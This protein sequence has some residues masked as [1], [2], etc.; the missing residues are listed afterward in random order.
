MMTIVEG[1]GWVLLHFVWQGA[2]IALALAIA[3]ALIGERQARLRYALSC[4]ALT[5]MLAATLSTAA[6]VWTSGGDGASGLLPARASGAVPAPAALTAARE[7]RTGVPASAQ[8]RAAS[9]LETTSLD[10]TPGRWQVVGAALPWLVAAWIGG[11]LLLSLRL[12]GGWWHTRALRAVDVAPVPDWCEARLAM[13]RDRLQIIRPVAIVSSIRVSVPVIVGHLK[14]VIV[15]PAAAL[16]G[17]SPAHL[18]AIIAHE[19]AHVR[20]HDYLVNLAQTVIETLLFY[21]PAVW[22][23]SRQVRVAREHCCDDLA[24]TVCSS[25]HEYVRALLDLE[26]L[27]DATPTLALGATD[28]SL[29]ARGRRLL[30]PQ[31]V[32]TSPPRLAASVIALVVVAAAVTGA[33]FNA[34]LDPAALVTWESPRGTPLIV[35]APSAIEASDLALQSAPVGNATPVTI[36][37][38]TAGPLANQW[39]WAIG[40]ARTA[41]HR[42]FWVGYSISPVKTLPAFVY[43][44]R[45]GRIVSGDMTFSGRI[46][47]SD[48]SGLRVPGRPLAL[49][50]ANRGVK[51]LFELDASRGEPTLASVHLSTLALPVDTKDLAV[52]WLGAADAAQS[53]DRIDQFYRAARDPEVRHDLV[54][55]AGAHDN[56]TA[57]VAWLERRIASQESD[58]LRGDAAESLAYH[59]IRASVTALDRTARQDRSTHVRQEAAE[60]L[61]DLPLP[62]ATPVLIDLARTLSDTDARREAVEALGARPEAAAAEAL[63]SI[64]RQDKDRDI[65]REAVETLGDFEDKRGTNALMELAQSHPDVEVRREAI[66]TLGDVLPTDTAVA[67]LKRFLADRDP[68]IVEEAIDAI[69]ANDSA[70]S[71]ATLMELARSHSSPDVRQKAVE[72]LASV[73]G[74]LEGQAGSDA[75][76]IVDL[77]TS[78]ANTDRALE[79]QIEATESL[80]EI[81]GA[82]AA[83]ALRELAGT[84]PD[85]EVRSEAIESL[86]E[87]DAAA[88]DTADFLKRL[89]LADKSHDVQSEALEALTG[90]RGGAGVGAL[91]ELAREHPDPEVRKD[92]LQQ[93]LDSNHPDAKALFDRALKKN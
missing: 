40:A 33:S 37:P 5:L 55:V 44:D 8:S 85:E 1:V 15:L 9:P 67:Q 2:I 42:I 58:D 50:A 60:A 10:G 36:S 86:G 13:L 25:R 78:L 49:P 34:T 84:H 68:A 93:L 43:Y 7:G 70:S 82:A 54:G 29:L 16:S 81:G 89:V 24:V 45:S 64:A 20:R 26:E 39:A 88:S 17:L 90:L 63:T 62:E 35:Y 28:G 48:M 47:S 38:D 12:L 91:I 46:Q 21:H 59:P 74:H 41:R 30:V 23:V 51:V 31:Q 87:S 11:V 4:L 3:L 53:L 75:R 61:G 52:F 27:R 72:E 18:D 56:S 19:L 83:T 79:V 14:P 65:Q 69:A 80:G 66:E 57:V 32:R 73:A 92:A 76:A 71:R 6:A 77:L 22:W